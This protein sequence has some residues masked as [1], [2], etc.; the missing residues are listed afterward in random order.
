MSEKRHPPAD[1]PSFDARTGTYEQSYDTTD[2]SDVL[3]CAIRSVAHIADVSPVEIEPVG[4][5]VDPDALV[6]AV[7]A[8]TTYG[9]AAVAVTVSIHEH[10]VTIG[11]GRIVIEPPADFDRRAGS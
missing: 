5:G 1:G 4:E 6:S 7:E 9:D 2:G 11:G 10:D 3:I 8:A